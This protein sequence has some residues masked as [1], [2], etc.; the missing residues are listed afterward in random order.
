MSRNW[1]EP[2]DSELVQDT[3]D[4][5]SDSLD[6]PDSSSDFARAGHQARND[7]QDLGDSSMENRDRAEK[8]NVPDRVEDT[9]IQEGEDDA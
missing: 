5:Q 9:D 3:K 2:S 1:K 4:F 7:M 8:E 6:G